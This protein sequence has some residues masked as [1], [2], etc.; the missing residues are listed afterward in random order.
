MAYTPADLQP[1]D[2]LLMLPPAQEPIWD[3]LLDDAIALSSGGPFVHAAL[4]GNDCL[5]EQV[6]TVQESPLD[7]YA[8]NGWRYAVSGATATEAQHV[9]AAFRARL[10]APYNVRELLLMG[11]YYDG[12]D[13]ALLDARFA[14]TV[15]STAVERAWRTVGRVLSCCPLV[16]PTGLAFSPALV[17]PRPWDRPVS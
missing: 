8:A 1:G 9:I 10:G 6:A 13:T 12:H 14:H 2:V 11:L 17:G 15:C 4:V 7:K 5:I 16:S 3:R